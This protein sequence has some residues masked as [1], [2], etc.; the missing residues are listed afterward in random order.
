MASTAEV[1]HGIHQMS[2]M[3]MKLLET[4]PCMAYI[5]LIG[6]GHT[7]EIPKALATS[8]AIDTTFA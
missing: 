6:Y 2:Y 4:K 3:K 8:L 7:R 5:P 1:L